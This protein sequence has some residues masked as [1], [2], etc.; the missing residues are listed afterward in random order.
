MWV[1]AETQA[2][3]QLCS[4]FCR[5]SQENPAGKCHV[6]YFKDGEIYS[7]VGT[8]L[9][10]VNIDPIEK[11]PFYHF[12]P[13]AKALSF[14]TVGCNFHCAWCQ[15]HSLVT[16]AQTDRLLVSDFEKLKP[17]FGH[18][19]NPEEL[20]QIAC[21]KGIE[22]LAYTY[23]EPTVFFEQALRLAELALQHKKANLFVSNGY[24]SKQTFAVLKE[25]IHAF[26]IDIKAFS[27]K[28]Y[29][30]FCK[31]SLRPVLDSCVRVKEA[32]LHLEVTTLLIPDLNDSTEELTQLAQFIAE[33]LGKE[34][35]WHISAFHPDYEMRNKKATSIETLEKAFT[36]GKEAG[37]DYIYYGNVPK[38]ND[39]LCPNCQTVLVKR[40][41][42]FVDVLDGFTGTCPH[43]N[44]EIK[45]IWK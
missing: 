12:K 43:C 1:K 11:K 38:E 29:A 13:R 5:L 22:A 44:Y 33:K 25:Y 30:E 10:A 42:Y 9:A 35:V 7:L 31:A 40:N 16:A 24:F 26:N 15:N 4:H 19:Y 36:V 6:R 39:T 2:V 20:I 27:E 21:Q 17:L 28:T 14:G 45:G 3:C 32:G 37:L 34:T 8:H 41:G 18:V 23:N